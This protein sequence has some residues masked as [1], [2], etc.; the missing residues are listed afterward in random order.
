MASGTQQDLPAP[1]V[2]RLTDFTGRAWVFDRLHAWLQAKAP[3]TFVL[4]GEPGSGKSTLAAR[5]VQLSRGEPTTT[6]YRH[7][8][9]GCL[10]YAHF[11]QARADRTLDPRRFVEALS[12]QLAA[13]YQPFAL[14]LTK[15]SEQDIIINATQTVGMA[16]R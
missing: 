13:R 10:A 2:D 6:T 14:A 16:E 8:G 5:L 9:S 11:C 1:L 7:L 3:Q 12:L 15:V 4:T